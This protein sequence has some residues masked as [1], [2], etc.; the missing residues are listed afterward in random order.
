[1]L[2][3]AETVVRANT[4]RDLATIAEA[5]VIAEV[6]VVAATAGAVVAREVAAT[7]EA[8]AA[9]EEIAG[10]ASENNNSTITFSNSNTCY[11]LRD[12]N[13]GKRRKAGFAKWPSVVQP[14]LSDHLL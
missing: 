9:E 3:T 5:V 2:P 6:V 7:A 11:S 4:N 13:T 14:S 10:N 1:M 12:Q 8:V